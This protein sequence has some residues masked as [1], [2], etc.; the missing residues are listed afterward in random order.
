M[1][2]SL[3]H[4]QTLALAGV[5]QSTGLVH[6][7]ATRGQ[8]DNDAMLVS[9]KSVL[10]LHPDSMEQ[11]IGKPADLNFGLCCIQA[12][13][14]GNQQK[15]PILQYSMLIMQLQ[16]NLSRDTQRQHAIGMELQLIHRNIPT[17]EPRLDNQDGFV[18]PA[19][20]QPEIISQLANVWTEQVRSLKPQIA[21]QGKPLYL[22][23]ESNVHL[24]RALLL[25]SLR[26]AWLWQQL[27]GSRWHLI[28]RRKKILSAAKNLLLA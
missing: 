16:Q 17:E 5:M 2:Y 20:L 22:Q 10:E 4:R 9:F 23:N 18:R 8:S 15:M 21:V 28:F 7:L 26:A 24:I 19:L 13:F 25:S 12:V 14:S 11:A 6:M 27:G 1:S 3:L